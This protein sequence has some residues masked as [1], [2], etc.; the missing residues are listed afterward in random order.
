MRALE[1]LQ[2]QFPFRT[3]YR[4]DPDSRS[5]RAAERAEQIFL[6]PGAREASS[7]LEVACSD[8]LVSSMLQR[9]GKQAVG[10]DLLATHFD[11]VALESGTTLQQM[12]AANLS[13]DDG[14]FHYAFSYNS[15]EHFHDP[16]AVLGEM[17][18]VVRKGGYIYLRFGPLYGSPWGEHAYRTIT[19]PYCQFLFSRQLMD[20]YALRHGLNPIKVDHVNGW[21]LDQFRVL[22]EKFAPVLRTVS[23]EET[24]DLSHLQI[25]RAYPSCFKAPA[26]PFEN[27]LV[28]HISV[29]FQKT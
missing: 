20:E 29:L 15:F 19:V 16:A 18:R 11:P 17:A 8:G 7:F 9:A 23:Y 24:Q 13:F 6:L 12:D 27:F 25:I 1:R 22:W 10:V 4:Y 26:W 21:S 14:R 3:A 28:S 2:P 5:R